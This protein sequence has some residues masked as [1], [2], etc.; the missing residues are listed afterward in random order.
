MG[1]WNA[2]T[3]VLV[4]IAVAPMPVGERLRIA[5]NLG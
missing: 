3:A 5:K 1:E 4:A 2:G